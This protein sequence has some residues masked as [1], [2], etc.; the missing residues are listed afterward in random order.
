MAENDRIPAVPRAFGIARILGY[1][2]FLGAFFLPAVRQVATPGA[3]PPEVYKGWF[4]AWTTLIN[5]L[6]RQTWLS[7]DFLAILSGWINPL[8]LIYVACLFSQKLRP[9]RVVAAALI[10]LFFI[11]TW[12]YF[13]LFPLVPLVG[14]VL[15]FAG[16]LMIVS[17][18]FAP[19]RPAAPRA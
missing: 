15:W 8:M 9:V 17:S 18:D 13:K 10:G 6:N 5:T 2:V 12:I 14:H 11:G 3:G 1:F 19:R 7:N 4:C 16:A